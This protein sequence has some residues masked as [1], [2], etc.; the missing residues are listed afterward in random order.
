M[1]TY[2]QNGYVADRVLTA[3]PMELIRMLYEGAL[4]SIDVAVEMLR[5]NNITARGHAITKAMNIVNELRASLDSGP[6]PEIVSSLTELYLYIH[7]RLFYAHAHK[8]EEALLEASRLLKSL[9]HGWLDV[10]KRAAT[11]S[12]AQ[13]RSFIEPPEVPMAAMNPYASAFDCPTSGRSWAV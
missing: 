3:S 7:N 8:S 13:Q 2:Q 11:E 4:S 5:A 10:M 6:Q 9:Y 12:A 1:Q